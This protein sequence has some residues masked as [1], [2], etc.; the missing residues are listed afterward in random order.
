[1]TLRPVWL[2]V[3]ACPI[4]AADTPAGKGPPELQGTWRL[5]SVES[6]GAVNEFKDRQPRLVIKGDRIQYGSE[7][8][9]QFTADS[10]ADPKSID[11]KFGK[12]DAVIEGVYAADR[13][14][15]KI[16]L[17][18]QVEG[19]KERPREFGTKNRDG[20]RLL[21]LRRETEADAGSDGLTGYIGVML[22][23]NAEKKEVAITAALDDSPAKKAGI[24]KDDV[25]LA[26]NNVAVSDLMSAVESI[27]GLKPGS[28]LTLRVRRDEKERDVT[29]KVGVLP[30]RFLVGLDA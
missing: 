14:S 19:V 25:F 1:M 26:T 28:E 15:L 24:Q 5:V 23:F 13:D 12:S 20:F 8:L 7:E 2:V 9:A 22:A 17:N 21:V 16:C 10:T 29:M 4:A 6:N 18:K 3:L 30:F 11:M 27:R